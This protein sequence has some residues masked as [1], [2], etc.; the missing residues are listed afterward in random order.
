MGV[1]TGLKVNP[2]ELTK[3]EIDPG[4]ALNRITDP[5]NNEEISQEILVSD[6]HPNRVLDLSGYSTSDQ[7]YISVSYMEELAD[8]DL[9]KGGGKKFMC[10]KKRISRPAP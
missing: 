6:T 1:V 3:V 2:K 9:L 4:F 10:G 7:I 8:P 5:D